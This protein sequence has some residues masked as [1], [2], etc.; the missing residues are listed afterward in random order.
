MKLL[1][2]LYLALVTGCGAVADTAACN[3][4]D[5]QPEGMGR[6][7]DAQIH[8]GRLYLTGTEFEFRPCNKDELYLVDASFVIRER[9]D[10]YISASSTA[11]AISLY[12]RFHGSEINCVVD[13]P[14]RYANVVKITELLT[15]GSTLPANCY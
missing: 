10:Q 4:Q 1:V 11:G 7:G 15:H 12:V 14:E 2:S 8:Q 6:I 3:A 9:L 5:P 13:L